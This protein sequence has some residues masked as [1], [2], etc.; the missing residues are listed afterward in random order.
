MNKILSVMQVSFALTLSQT[1]VNAP[2]RAA[3]FFQATL[4][5]EQEV[6][7]GGATNSPA[8]GFANLELND[9]GDELAYSITVFGVDFSNLAPVPS[10]SNPLDV[11]TLLHIHQAPRGANGGVAFGIFGQAQ[12]LDDR[13]VTFNPVD[14]S[15]TISGV[16]DVDDPASIPCSQLCGKIENP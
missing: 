5:S 9:A 4:N 1:F 11:A 15:T 6:A 13:V 16:W 3:Q 14:E 8:T 7:P 2:A 10:P 12:D